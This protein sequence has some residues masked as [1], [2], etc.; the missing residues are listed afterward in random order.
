[1]PRTLRVDLPDR[2]YDIRIGATLAD[3]LGGAI[4]NAT[5]VLIVTD[6]NVNPLYGQACKQI[7]GGQGT[8][9]ACAEIPA[10]EKSKNL[11]TVKLLYTRAVE[12]GLD[13]ASVVVALGGGVVG[14]LAGFV[15]ASYMRGIG[16]V[17]V[18][19]TLLAMVDSS[20]G[21]KTGVNL[22]QGKNLVGAFYQPRE[23]LIDLGVLHSLPEVE[24]IAGLAEVVK[25][26]LIWDAVLF[27]TLEDNVE[28][29]LARDIE[30]L[31]KIVARCCEI[32]AE[33]VALDEHESGVRAILNFGHTFG[34]AVEQS[35]GYGEWLHGEAV[36][37]G[38]LYAA[39]ISTTCKRFPVV[40]RDRLEALLTRLGLP[41]RTTAK[42]PSLSWSAVRGAM[43]K[44]KKSVQ[45]QPRFVLAERMG[46]VVFGCEIEEDALERAA[47]RLMAEE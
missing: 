27:S 30:F 47:S 19:T 17:Q 46:S 10:G 12:A 5:N 22:P 21:G 9:V 29:L 26:G 32:K 35:T 42:S 8:R 28:G 37:V 31:E 38:M 4:K 24:Y 1:M 11:E 23:V 13:R 33:V 43:A 41:V 20:V 6:T 7:L 44:D 16:F 45:A 14:D 25:Y 2:G 34:H 3:G 40:E 39:D 18:P 15:A 36:S